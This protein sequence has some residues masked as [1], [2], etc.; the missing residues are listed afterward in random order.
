MNPTPGTQ[1]SD[2]KEA[3]SNTS[4]R[5]PGT[6]TPLRRTGPIHSQG[7]CPQVATSFQDAEN[8]ASRSSEGP[9][10]PVLSYKDAVVVNTSSGQKP[11][12]TPMAAS[13][14]IWGLRSMLLRLPKSRESQSINLECFLFNL[15]SLGR[16]KDREIYPISGQPS[17][18]IGTRL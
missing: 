13:K 18:N 4:S 12:D 1:M 5:I 10:G 11:G 16:G 6:R 15:I 17:T 3:A 14:G 2:T 9:I 8:L 7:Q